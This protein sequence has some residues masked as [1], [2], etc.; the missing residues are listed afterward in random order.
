MRLFRSR[1]AVASV[2]AALLSI[3]LLGMF[4]AGLVLVTE[5][6][7]QSVPE[8]VKTSEEISQT[9]KESLEA[10]ID[11]V[12]GNTVHIRVKNTGSVTARIEEV[13]ATKSDGSLQIVKIDPPETLIP[14]EE[15]VFPVTIF[16]RY[17]RLGLLTDRGKVYVVNTGSPPQ[18]H[19]FDFTVSVNPSS[20]SVQQGGSIQTTVTVAL[21]SGSPQTVTLSA[22]GLPGEAS[23]SFSTSSGNPT[24]T[25]ILTISVG[26]STPTRTYTI[27][28]AGTGGGLTRTATYTLT[29]TSAPQPF[30]FSISVNPQSGSVQQGGS[31]SAAVNVGLVSGSTQSV[32]LS[33]SGLPSGAP[34]SFKP[35][36]GTPSFTST[37]TISTSMSTPT[38]RYTITITGAGGG[39]TRTA[40][41]TLTVTQQPSTTATVTFSANGLEADASG[42]V[43]MV[44]GKGYTYSRLPISFSWA[45]GSS[46]V[47]EWLT[48]I[49]AGSTKRYVWTS[50]SG[51]STS[52][53]G[54]ITVPSGGGSV[55]AN[56]KTQYQWS[57]SASGL[58]EDA[59]G[60]V[61]TV[62]GSSY[63]YS[64]LSAV[65][66]WDKGS[67]HSY[68]YQEYVR[69]TNNGKRY[70][71]HRP[72]SS[73]VT[74]TSSD[75]RS[76][77]YHA[78]YKLTVKVSPSGSGS[79]NP[80]PGT[81]WYDTG[82]SVSVTASP[83]TG[84]V[85]DRWVLDGNNVG[86]SSPIAV[87]MNDPHI[88]EAKFTGASCVLEVRVLRD[89][90][91]T[92]I[93]G[94]TVKIDGSPYTTSSSGKV[95]VSVSY[96]S[97][98]IEVV[99]PYSPSSGTRYVFTRWSD[100]STGNPRSVSVTGATSLTAYMKLQYYLTMKTSPLTGGSVSPSSG[101]RDADSRVTISATPA[102][103]YRFDR[104]VG[105]GSGSYTG[106]SNPAH[107][108]MNSPITETANFVVQP[109]SYTVTFT[110]TG[111]P[112]GTSWS[113]TFGGTTKSST[114]SSILFSD[115]LAGTH[116][117]SVSS[118]I[119]GGS[120]IQYVASPSSGT[121]R[122]PSQTSQSIT[123]T[124]Q[125]M[126]SI[127]VSPSGAGTTSPSPGS[128]WYD[129]GSSVTVTASPYS[130]YKFDRWELDGVNKGSSSS[131]I[132]TMNSPH[133]LKAVF[134]EALAAVTFYISNVGYDADDVE[135]L[136]VDG[137]WYKRRDLPKTFSWQVGSSH[138]VTWRE[139]FYNDITSYVPSYDVKYEWARSTGIFTSRSGAL[140]VPSNGGSVT[141]HY[142]V[143]YKL[144]VAYTSGGSTSQ[145]GSSWREEGSS[146]SVE[147][148]PY[149]GYLFDYWRVDG[150]WNS[151]SNPITVTMNIPHKLEA[152]FE[153]H[154][155][156]VR[157]YV[158]DFEG[159]AVSNVKVSLG[160]FSGYTNSY[161]Y[162]S[163]QVPAGTYT[164]SVPSRTIAFGFS[165]GFYRW[166]GG[167]TSRSR[168]ITVSGDAAY[169]AIYKTALKLKKHIVGKAGLDGPG[170]FVAS[171]WV[172]SSHGNPVEEASVHATFHIH[173]WL[174]GRKTLSA[175]ATSTSYAGV[176]GVGWFC[177]D[178]YSPLDALFYGIEYVN[179]YASKEGYEP[180]SAKWYP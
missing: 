144:Y 72:P 67:S 54:A 121:M 111:L 151:Y 40:T 46:H 106:S 45:V 8:A 174:F 122:V 78:E 75:S 175:S 17:S 146:V 3:M 82:S 110:Q 126:L 138:S 171:G 167:S 163:L 83:N 32:T 84:Y 161:G 157:V 94:V 6:Q 79:T 34:Y 38:G 99:S 116:S 95:S 170:W 124:K 77:S 133:M 98:S 156:T 120:G 41:Y 10:S 125:Y 152:Y 66:W 108:T 160:S 47:F 102:S 71:C 61:V 53:S 145:S 81:Y 57:F 143:Y 128:H 5:L 113:V 63:G 33:A 172:K 153:E 119:S 39:L 148:T 23:A 112:I 150:S 169:T 88:L 27:T 4:A 36:S 105:S 62:D 173:S 74:V 11:W 93:Q 139:V 101:W 56:F 177:C 179:M 137:V 73:A 162:I 13:L 132:V 37:I 130:G 109:S 104:W 89:G 76:P 35:S 49:S 103:D 115:V 141:A 159:Y 155:Y 96:G 154:K 114:G 58:G 29:V 149:S 100:G 51:L 44:D 21:L 90:A 97:H 28:V 135:V 30:D 86:S 140:T 176:Y 178:V 43:L 107:I 147:A 85:F 80:A 2:V 42:N 7:N 12:T 118:P 180:A 26:T 165:V 64:S 25:S 136:Y 18:P 59:S 123:Y 87:T 22:S 164:L 117:W 20:G 9:V 69:T 168:T 92:G 24:F 1:R 16:G 68:A 127:S 52:R 15:K 91:G 65:F 70:A 142:N 129:R 14:M 31:V 50:T 131:M 134:K 19:P 48:P 55:T 60:T 158:R 166:S